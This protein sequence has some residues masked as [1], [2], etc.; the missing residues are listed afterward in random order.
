MSEAETI[1]KM[2]ETV[3][4]ADT[5]KLD[6]IDARV[7]CWLSDCDYG[8]GDFDNGS[9]FKA[10]P[11]RGAPPFFKSVTLWERYTRSRDAL[12]VMRPDE[13]VPIKYSRMVML[14]AS[15]F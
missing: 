12:K 2:I 14:P 10:I 13:S 3:D 4:P 15:S 6:E 5:A 7:W 8:G 1:L 9:T 11:K